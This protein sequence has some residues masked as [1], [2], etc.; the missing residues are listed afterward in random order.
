MEKK[1]NKLELK[2]NGGACFYSAIP[3]SLFYRIGIVGKVGE[4]FDVSVF[5][6]YNIDLK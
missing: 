1:K 2:T 3:A 4:D 5:S 6:N